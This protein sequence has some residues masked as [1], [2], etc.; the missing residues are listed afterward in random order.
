MD[1]GLLRP[2][3]RVHFQHVI[4]RLGRLISGHHRAYTYLPVS[5][6]HFLTPEEFSATLD[7]AGFDVTLVR[8]LMGGTVALHVA[9]K[10]E[11]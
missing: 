4:P 10:R 1:R 2:F 3:A 7:A 11:A 6:D 5:V 8:R 9:E